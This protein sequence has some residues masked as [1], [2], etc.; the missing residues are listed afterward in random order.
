MV[1]AAIIK[2]RSRVVISNSRMVKPKIKATFRLKIRFSII[3]EKCLEIS[4]FSFVDQL[5]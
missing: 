2:V 4:E 3:N 5:I 1:T